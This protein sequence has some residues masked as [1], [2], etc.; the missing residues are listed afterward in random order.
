[1]TP[2]MDGIGVQF[3]PSRG[4]DVRYVW[5]FVEQKDEPSPLVLPVGD[6]SSAKKTAT[7]I[8][9]FVREHGTVEGCG[10]RHGATPFA[11]GDRD[12]SRTP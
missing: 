8:K 9:E 12:S 11:G 5:G 3:D 4:Y 2:A 7:L 1:M 10:A 6:G